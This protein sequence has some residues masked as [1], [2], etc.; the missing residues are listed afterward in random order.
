MAGRAHFCSL[1]FEDFGGLKAQTTRKIPLVPKLP[2]NSCAFGDITP[3]PG[4]EPLRGQV[5]LRRS[6]CFGL[7]RPQ[8]RIFFG[9]GTCSMDGCILLQVHEVKISQQRLVEVA[10][11]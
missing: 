9:S 1:F 4:G 10:N 8:L 3:D 7:K 11:V 6:L 2:F 5:P